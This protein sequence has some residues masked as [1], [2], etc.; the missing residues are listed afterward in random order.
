MR[1]SGLDTRAVALHFRAI[2]YYLTGAGIDESLG[3]AKGSSA[4]EPV[5]S[6]VAARDFPA[7]IGIGEFFG[8]TH[9]AELFEHGLNILLDRMEADANRARPE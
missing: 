2:S 6:D 3:Y 9:H 5:P 8:Q 7:I 1:E 4:I